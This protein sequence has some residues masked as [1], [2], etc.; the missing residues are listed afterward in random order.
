MLTIT[1]GRLVDKISMCIFFHQ[2]YCVSGWSW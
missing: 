1:D 2:R